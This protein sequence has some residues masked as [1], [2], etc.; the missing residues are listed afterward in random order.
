VTAK[1]VA[2]ELLSPATGGFGGKPHD[3]GATPLPGDSRGSRFSSYVVGDFPVPTGRE[4]DWRFTPLDRLRHLHEDD[5]PG[6]GT[7]TVE[8]DAAPELSVEAV[9]RGDAR[10]GRGGE[11]AD[12]VAARAWKA[13]EKATVITVPSEAVASRETTVS[14]RGTGVDDGPAF[15][16]LLVDVQPFAKAVVVLDHTGSATYAE[17]IELLASTGRVIESTQLWWSVRPHHSF[18]TVEVR[19]CDAQ[20]RGE[21]AS[22]TARRW[23]RPRPG[24]TSC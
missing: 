7:V 13:F 23:P 3:H 21:D 17:F 10:L 18:G 15:G 2:T 14:V 1:P 12:R 5:G 19:I 4:E 22:A 16:H 11:P 8:V 24:S 9:A 6:T 20:T